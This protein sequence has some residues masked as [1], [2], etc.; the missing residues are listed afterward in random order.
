MAT[1]ET[2]LPPDSSNERANPADLRAPEKDSRSGPS[3][4]GIRN[5]TIARLVMS[6]RRTL[7][8]VTAHAVEGDGNFVDS[9]E[10]Y[11]TSDSGSVAH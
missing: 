10:A 6:N 11:R 1:L 9:A 5:L 4:N 7:I 3:S 2:M 8:L